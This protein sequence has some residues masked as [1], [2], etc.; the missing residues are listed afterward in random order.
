MGRSGSRTSSV[1][2]ASHALLTGAIL[3]M[4]ILW[5]LNTL[6]EG[7]KNACAGGFAQFGYESCQSRDEW[8]DPT[9]TSMLIPLP[10]LKRN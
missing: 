8:C 3:V 9:S 4:G 10:A 7:A 6:C 1:T 5:E 2:W